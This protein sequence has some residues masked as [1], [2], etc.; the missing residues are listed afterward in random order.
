M[1]LG[2]NLSNLRK[3]HNLS[4]EEFSEKINI[5]KDKIKDWENEVKKPSI[6]EIIILSNFFDLSI[7]V[8]VKGEDNDYVKISK[9]QLS[10]IED[11][12]NI[13]KKGIKYLQY[14]GI[15]IVVVFLLALIVKII[16]IK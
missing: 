4:I 6:E 15:L 3:I 14:T 8:L 9:N 10:S 5:S 12:S 1:K 13:I 7:D 2:K 11:M 16:L